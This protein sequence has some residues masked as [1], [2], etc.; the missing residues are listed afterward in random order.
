MQLHLKEIAM[1]IINPAT[2]YLILYV[3]GFFILV[4]VHEQVHVEIFRGYDVKSHI[5]WFY[6]DS[7]AS[8]IPDQNSTGKCTDTCELAHNINEAI[9]YPLQI[10]YVIFGF[11]VFIILVELDMHRQELELQTEQ[12]DLNIEKELNNNEKVS[13]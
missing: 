1:I 2:V 6:K 8:A 3:L 5:E 13:D 9:T 11:A 7:L 12:M 10:F 4:Q